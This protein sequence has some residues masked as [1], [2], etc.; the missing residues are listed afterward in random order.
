[1]KIEI[2]VSEECEGTR[3]PWWMIIDPRQSFRTDRE[4]SHWV[5]SMITGPFF[6]REEAESVLKASRYNFGKGAVVYCASGANTI[7]YASKVKF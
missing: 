3:S 2:E 6:S 1:V 7:Q 5:A 4:A